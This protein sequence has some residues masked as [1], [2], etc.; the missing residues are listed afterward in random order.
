[1]TS[2]IPAGM[3]AALDRQL[4]EAVHGLLTEA[5]RYDHLD[6]IEA[7]AELTSRLLALFPPSALAASTAMLALRVHRGV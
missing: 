7:N 5:A 6:L 2:P 1:M 3:R 4:E